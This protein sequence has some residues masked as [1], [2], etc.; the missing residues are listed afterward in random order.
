MIYTDIYEQPWEYYREEEYQRLAFECTIPGLTAFLKTWF[1]SAAKKKS[2]ST[3]YIKTFAVYIKAFIK[4][5]Y[6]DI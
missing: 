4:S 5:G 6:A 2:S 1:M 3:A